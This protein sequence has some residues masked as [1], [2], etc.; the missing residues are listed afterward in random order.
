MY[1]TLPLSLQSE[2]CL[3]VNRCALSKSP[4]FQKLDEGFLRSIAL[5]IKNKFYLPGQIV[6]N[7]GTVSRSMYYI[8]RGELEVLSDRDNTTAVAVLRA[9]KLFGEVNLVLNFARTATIRAATHCDLLVLSQHDV[10]P[11][12]LHYPDAR[13]AMWV[14]VRELFD[15]DFESNAS[16]ASVTAEK[17]GLVSTR[18]VGKQ[19]SGRRFSPTLSAMAE[20]DES[21]ITPEA[22][23]SLFEAKTQ[24]ENENGSMPSKKEQG[25]S[26]RFPKLAHSAGFTGNASA[27]TLEQRNI[28]K[29]TLMMSPSVP[30][31]R[32]RAGSFESFAN[33]SSHAKLQNQSSKPSTQAGQLDKPRAHFSPSTRKVSSSEQPRGSAEQWEPVPAF[34]KPDELTHV[35]GSGE[36]RNRRFTWA[37]GESVYKQVRRPTTHILPLDT[38]ELHLDNS[39]ALLRPEKV[40][41]KTLVHRLW[42][43]VKNPCIEDDGRF[44]MVWKTIVCLVVIAQWYIY[45]YYASF[46]DGYSP[47]LLALTYLLDTVHVVDIVFSL[48][49]I[50]ISPRKTYETYSDIFHY[51][52]KK[53]AFYL[54]LLAALPLDLICVPF[55]ISMSSVRPSRLVTICKLNKLAKV[56]V[57]PQRFKYLEDQ[58]YIPLSAIRPVELITYILMGIHFSACLWFMDS[59]IDQILFEKPHTD[60][61]MEQFTYIKKMEQ[62]SKANTTSRGDTY[63]LSLY[64][65]A[66]TMSTTGYGDIV[67]MTTLEYHISILVMVFGLVLFAFSLA[68]YASLLT[69][70]E[71]PKINFQ[72]I[73]FAMDQFMVENRLDKLLRMRVLRYLQLQWHTYNGLV[74][75]GNAFLLYDLPEALQEDLASD[76]I[77]KLLGDIP[78]FY[79]TDLA[80]RQA[81]G[82]KCSR[83]L[84]PPNEYVLYSGDL[85]RDMYIVV[86]GYCESYLGNREKSLGLIGPGQYFGEAGM[87][88]GLP[89]PT[90]VVTRTHC[91][92]LAVPHS[93]FQRI[94][95][96]FPTVNKEICEIQE[97]A[98]V[99][100][101]VKLNHARVWRLA[102]QFPSRQGSLFTL[103]EPPSF[104]KLSEEER[105]E[106]E[107]QNPFDRLGRLSFLGRLLMQRTVRPDGKFATRL[108]CARLV[109]IMLLLIITPVHV[110]FLPQALGLY[111]IGF[112]LDATTAAYMYLRL[113]S[114]YYDASCTLVSHPLL[115]ATNY[116]VSAFS[117]DM[118]ASF[119]FDIVAMLF[120]VGNVYE[121][122]HTIV[123]FRLNRLVQA[124]EFF[125]AFSHWEKEVLLRRGLL[126][127]IKHLCYFGLYVHIIACFWAYLACPTSAPEHVT[128]WDPEER[129]LEFHYHN[130]SEFIS[131]HKNCRDIS[132]YSI[133][134]FTKYRGP[135][136]FYVISVLFT[137]EMVASVGYGHITP[138]TRTEYIISIILMVHGVI[139][140]GY[141]I[142]SVTASLVNADTTRAKFNERVKK[143]RKQMLYEVVPVVLQKKVVRHIE[144]EFSRSQGMQAHL[145]F[146]NLPPSIRGD[147]SFVLFES[148]ISSV[149]I[150]ETIDNSFHRMLAMCLK[151]AFFLEGETVIFAGDMGQEM[152]FIHRG[153]CEIIDQEGTVT[154]C[155]G[156]GR[157]FG[158]VSVMYSIPRTAT[159]RAQTNTDLFVLTKSDLQDVL[160]NYPEIK[161]EIERI[162]MARLHAT[163]NRQSSKVSQN[164]SYR[165]LSKSPG[166]PGSGVGIGSVEMRHGRKHKSHHSRSLMDQLASALPRPFNSSER[167]E[168]RRHSML[169]EEYQELLDQEEAEQRG[170]ARQV[171]PRGSFAQQVKQAVSSFTHDWISS[172]PVNFHRSGGSHLGLS[173]GHIA[174]VGSGGSEQRAQSQ[175]PPPAESG[176]PAPIPSASHDSGPGGSQPMIKT[177][178]ANTKESAS[179]TQ[180]GDNMAE[181]L[182]RVPSIQV[183]L[184]HDVVPDEKSDVMP[185]SSGSQRVSPSVSITSNASGEVREVYMSEQTIEV[186]SKMSFDLEPTDHTPATGRQS[187][188]SRSSVDHSIKSDRSHV[189]YHSMRGE[190]RAP[191][192]FTKWCRCTGRLMDRL[193][194]SNFVIN[195]ESR[196]L[197]IFNLFLTVCGAVSNAVLFY[198]AAF[199]DFSVQLDVV[200]GLC[201][202]V[203]IFNIYVRMHTAYYDN[204]GDLVRDY[205]TVRRFYMHRPTGFLVD[206]LSAL[207]IGVLI[208]IKPE[209]IVLRRTVANVRFVQLTRVYM[210]YHFFRTWE[211]RLNAPILFLR[212]LRDLGILLMLFHICACFW[213]IVACPNAHCK[214]GSWVS[215]RHLSDS[216]N[217]EIYV[218]SVYFIVATMTSSGYG[219]IHPQTM[220][221]ATLC[222][223]IIMLGKF[224]LGKSDT[225]GCLHYAGTKCSQHPMR[226]FPFLIVTFSPPETEY[227]AY[228][229]IQ[230]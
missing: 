179:K 81:L 103:D 80:F 129:L 17:S 27:A 5:K 97:N 172:H 215:K 163:G 76:G 197:L 35:T 86:R 202:C 158:E 26:S 119:P 214:D 195:P 66:A 130:H 151:E 175:S 185:A 155:L 183:S 75:S 65:A 19:S 94:M 144:Y 96:K 167:H 87:L 164:L 109:V 170:D 56:W 212:S 206:V 116:L 104:V 113:H 18:P 211:R 44:A 37:K 120:Y 4:M 85:S 31:F 157:F 145:L 15:T 1:E 184:S 205:K 6:I 41:D 128:P 218:N 52:I 8:V 105:K 118:I 62:V 99:L 43:I 224:A 162:A 194:P 171:T 204:Y 68:S 141:I 89:R 34:E 58:L 125:L 9:G 208:L 95:K 23:L 152:Y 92:L 156:P 70:Q 166:A 47:G 54:D 176:A 106:G 50:V 192:C 114:A 190:L 142:A 188:C 82:R 110:T 148:L 53:V 42:T 14:Y 7:K 207:P 165:R 133:S 48:M 30:V 38:S 55:V 126:K 139:F 40:H 84:F 100:R 153:I 12:L 61:W 168:Q 93:E 227:D 67:A 226:C 2:I 147:V 98:A 45:L 209:S 117:L 78:L 177:S 169:T 136:D 137:L 121:N 196:L 3:S 111:V 74:M 143:L 39:A 193:L 122:L 228:A 182:T 63:I 222:I 79:G 150:F 220:D 21:P 49:T 83:Y 91:D 115:T 225:R 57:I 149:P 189:S 180:N 159:I 123:L 28:A 201:T 72:S 174:D 216:T 210:A 135:L 77:V 213:Y 71:R 10:T 112:M 219:D 229:L 20:G 181:A 24:E 101:A 36:L 138:Q 221:E 90:H 51:R 200:L 230:F 203:Y 198:Q 124:Y 11:V 199:V 107:G 191:S 160:E 217:L 108:A 60:M 59:N 154:V 161:R 127:A 88:Y 187:Q 186:E 33:M 69:N 32:E 146:S 16:L 131:L 25:F 223:P 13:L 173:A 22:K 64:W 140:F 73:V 134:G 178:T 46:E 132:W 29:D 102:S